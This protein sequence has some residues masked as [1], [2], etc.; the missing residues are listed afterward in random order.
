MTEVRG[1]P[2]GVDNPN[3]EDFQSHSQKRKQGTGDFLFVQILFP[4]IIKKIIIEN[5]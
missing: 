1:D 5:V 2:Q 4:G 3:K